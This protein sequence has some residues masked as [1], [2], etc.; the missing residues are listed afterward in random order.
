MNNKHAVLVALGTR[1]EAI[2]LAPI[3][4][5]L[6]TSEQ[7][8]PIVVATAQH[9]NMLDQVLNFFE[10]TPQ[11]DLDLMKPNQD[12]YYTT[13]ECLMRMKNVLRDTSPEM[14][15]VQGDTTT[16]LSAALA[17]FY[18][19]V[20]IAHV[21]AGLRTFQKYS[22]FPEEMN[23]KLITPLADL[24]F[25]PTLSA[26]NHLLI[27]GVA[28]ENIAVTGNTAIDALLLGL[29]K[30]LTPPQGL[31]IDTHRPL[32]LLTLHRRENFGE[33]FI[34]ILSTVKKFAE[35]Y[36]NVQWV[37]PVHPNPNVKEI[38]H[39]FLGRFS[40]IS[41]IEPV[42]YQEMLF[43]MKQ[44]QFILTD[45][46]GI[47]EEAPSLGKP[48]LVLRE[49]T[50]RPEAVEA[51]VSFLVGHHSEI[52]YK[53]METLID[54]NSQLYKNMSRPKNPFGDG[55]A[56]QKIIQRMAYYF[57]EVRRNKLPEAA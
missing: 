29:T 54:R 43:L 41:L 1:P 57:R 24:H 2:K 26:K 8:T 34:E 12:L 18:Q 35:N 51:G 31:E 20:P 15:I 56:S 17:A 5:A 6:E 37:Y 16:A 19:R 23:R 49:S 44:A 45:S 36:P 4:K 28:E 9:R 27:E 40:N 7:F 13:S 38:A 33:P 42:G 50:E 55:T 11:Y 46:G 53:M 14:I 39:S 25:A 47:Q 10:I 22:P 32:V 52:I 21:E 3:I 48:V 30:T